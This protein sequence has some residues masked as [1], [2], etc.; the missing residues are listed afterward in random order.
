MIFLQKIS[1]KNAFTLQMIDYM[2]QHVYQQ[3]SAI[4][5]N[6]QVSQNNTPHWEGHGMLAATWAAETLG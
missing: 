6:F 3:D 2:D 1:V 5:K 4:S